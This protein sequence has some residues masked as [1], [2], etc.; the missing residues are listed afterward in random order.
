MDQHD[1]A[2]ESWTT[3]TKTLYQCAY[4]IFLQSYCIIFQHRQQFQNKIEIISCAKWVRAEKRQWMKTVTVQW[5]PT[6]LA[7]PNMVETKAKKPK[8]SGSSIYGNVI[9]Q[10]FEREVQLTQRDWISFSIQWRDKNNPSLRN[11]TTLVPNFYWHIWVD[12]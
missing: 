8:C 1:W 9:T 4:S 11:H 2:E 12:V 10:L 6:E 5:P 7:F 3:A